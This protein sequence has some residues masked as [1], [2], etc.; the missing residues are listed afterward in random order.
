VR[1][2]RAIVDDCFLL[3]AFFG[4]RDGE[5]NDAIFF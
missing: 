4:N 5:M 2:A 3:N 1:V